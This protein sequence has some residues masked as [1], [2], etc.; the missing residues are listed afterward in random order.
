MQRPVRR[1]HDDVRSHIPTLKNIVVR[2]E[3][4][5]IRCHCLLGETVDLYEKRISPAIRNI[6]GLSL[7]F[8]YILYP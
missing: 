8:Q 3:K 6:L 4:H 1:F 7:F 5:A 2:A